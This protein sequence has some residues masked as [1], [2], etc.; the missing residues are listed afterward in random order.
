[1]NDAEMYFLENRIA[2]LND[3]A[4]FEYNNGR[5]GAAEGLLEQALALAE[6]AQNLDMLIALRAHLSGVQHQ[7]GKGSE[8]LAGAS[9]L[10]GIATDPTTSGRVKE[11]YSL[12]VLASSF[13]SF[14]DVAQHLPGISTDD[15][16]RVLR[17]GEAWMARIGKPEWTADLRIQRGLILKRRGDKQGARREM[18][19]S[20]AI[21][22][23]QRPLMGF[24][25]ET[26]LFQLA[27]LL[28]GEPFKE[29]D[30]ALKLTDEIIGRPDCNYELMKARGIR[31]RCR[32]EMGDLDGTEQEARE[33]LAL[34][35]QSDRKD[36]RVEALEML[37]HLHKER[38]R[39][40]EA[41]ATFRE[42]AALV[43]DEDD[44]FTRLANSCAWEMYL[45]DEDLDEA[46]DLARRGYEK[47]R[48][49]T[50][51]L[52]TLTAILVR[53][54]RWD[55]A[56]ELVREWAGRVDEKYLGFQWH[57]DLLLFQ[58]TLKRGHA[59]ALAEMLDRDIWEPM[60]VALGK[61]A[62]GD[63]DLSDVPNRLRNA[64]ATLLAQL[65]GQDVP[66][67]YP[68]VESVAD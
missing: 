49:D 59:E 3:E 26:H 52:Q 60:R 17:D 61:A 39:R 15:L 54:D 2:I 41:V 24:S 23:R 56:A 21:K 12:G 13:A 33:M 10:I 9:W 44:Q 5:F 51:I 20:L 27:E 28:M 7:L 31:S 65:R 30:A 34:A 36:D 63:D 11:N 53:L 58:D 1:M 16:L 40:E 62:R 55:E 22:R 32:R 37:G 14:S 25:F 46:A 43:S 68:T 47:D 57:H 8:A 38:Q 6:Q 48:A 64:V 67:L 50:N 29:Y 19:A 66:L 42:A 45:A 35:R 4:K 18:E